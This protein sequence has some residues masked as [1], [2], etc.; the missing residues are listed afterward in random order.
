VVLLAILSGAVAALIIDSTLNFV[1]ISIIAVLLGSI[2]LVGSWFVRHVSRLHRAAPSLMPSGDNPPIKEHLKALQQLCESTPA[3]VGI[4]ELKGE[5]LLHIY[6]NPAASRFFASLPVGDLRPS[7]SQGEIPVAF[8]RELL[9]RCKESRARRAPIRFEFKA[10]E[11]V[12]IRWLSVSICPLLENCSTPNQFAYLAEDTTEL[13]RTESLLTETKER[14]TAALEQGSLAT[15]DWDIARNMVYGDTMLINLFGLPASFMRGMPVEEYV[16][17]IAEEDRGRVRALIEHALTTGAGYQAQFRVKTH[18]G[19][20]RWISAIGKVV[21]DSSGKPHRFPGVSMDITQL[22]QVEE[23]LHRATHISRQQLAELESVYTFAPVGLCVFDDKMRWVRINKTM[24]EYFGHAPEDH[25]GKSVRELLPG[26][27]DSLEGALKR[28]V[29]SKQS[30]LNVEASGE[31]PREPGMIRTWR[32]SFHPLVNGSGSVHG[33]SVVMEDITDE[34]RA[35]EEHLAHRTILEMVAAQAPLERIFSNLA[36]AVEKMFPGAT[37]YI[38]QGQQRGDRVTPFGVDYPQVVQEIFAEP[39]APDLRGVFSQVQMNASEVLISDVQRS[40]SDGFVERLRSRGVRSLWIKPILL[41]DG[42]V[43]GAC[44]VQHSGVS[45]RPTVADREHLE[46]L[47]KLASTAIER[48]RFLEQLTLASKRLQYAETVGKI[49]VF[50]WDISNDALVWT[51]QMEEI[52]GLAAGKFEGHIDDWRRRVHPD[53]L[54]EVLSVL[55]T[56]MAHREPTCKEDY[57]FVRPDGEVRWIAVQGAFEYSDSGSAARMIGVGT[58]ITDQ[59]IREEQSRLDKERLT[60]A[61]ESGALG[62]WD[63]NIQTGEVFYGGCWAS[64]LGYS[65]EEIAPS[66]CTWDELVHPEDKPGVDKALQSHIAG[67]LPEYESEFRLRKKDGSWLWVLSR[68]RLVSRDAKGAPLRAV[69]IHANVH[70]QHLIREE[71]RAAAKRK[72]EFLATLAHELRNPLAPLR[73]GLEILRRDPAGPGGIQAREMMD[74]QLIHMVHLV[75]DLLDV[76]RITRGKLELRRAELSLRSIVQVAVESS[77]PAIEAA[78]HRLA[79]RIPSEEVVIYGDATRLSQVVSNLLLNAAKYTPDH[80]LIE[81]EAHVRGRQVVLKVIDNGLGIPKEMLG[82]VFEMFG[83]VNQTL[84]RAQ[85][86]LGIGLAL[87]RNIIDLH[88]GRVYAESAGVG[89]GSSFTVELPIREVRAGTAQ[90]ETAAPAAMKEDVMKKVLIVDDN[91]DGAMSLKLYLEMLGYPVAVTHT[92]PD[93]VAYAAKEMPGI[94]FLDIGLPGM[95]GYEVAHKIREMPAGKQPVIAAVT[96]WGTDEDK[97]KSAEAGC[98]VHLTKP[99]DLSEAERLL[100]Q[101]A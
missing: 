97:R 84:E 23:A 10:Q 36:H 5:E 35:T 22:K 79:M 7:S 18:E 70:E 57:R 72:D 50:D 76:S 12:G 34:R 27:A 53:D 8:S 62:F 29:Q 68:G 46:V 101:G 52:F 51:P 89:K 92:G 64:M 45:I 32:S 91:V 16:D 2:L 13:K 94:I 1:P 58:D 41:S 11:A 75:D 26:L 19:K 38:V 54:P 24:A 17:R 88:G 49:G 39:V 21:Y 74:R 37:A 81:L 100:L 43:W 15:W 4:V 87:V 42:A 96:G 3:L 82:N 63:W 73:T 66:I 56:S 31:S 33:I 78:H 80:G 95:S 93:A 77:M 98:N 71:L 14:L 90:Q 99:I 85:G 60:L 55:A 44:V 65:S 30:V 40:N 48:K 9:I 86:G 25:V 67:E 59:K 47:L 20:T 83:Q 69:G 6:D 28:V 61:L